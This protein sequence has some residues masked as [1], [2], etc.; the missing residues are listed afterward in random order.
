MTTNDDTNAE[1]PGADHESGPGMAG[2]DPDEAAA[3]P[4]AAEPGAAASDAPA[5]PGAIDISAID[6]FA[7]LRAVAIRLQEELDAERARGA[8]HLD[9]VRRSQAEF[10]NYKKRILREQ[11]DIVERASQRVVE[12]LLPAVESLDLAAES[13]SDAAGAGGV[14]DGLD[15]IRG[16]IVEI[17]SKEG[18]EKIDPAPGTPVDPE[19]HEAVVRSQSAEPSGAGAG[20][21]V[22]AVLRPGYQFK[23]RLIRPAMVEFSD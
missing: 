23:Q 21:V 14:A 6:N 18:L 8:E 12:A 3:E 7:D 17:L 4:A 11:T 15:K 2:G 19:I 20:P 5:V 13:G 22:A 1:V 10:Q 16:Q 9:Q